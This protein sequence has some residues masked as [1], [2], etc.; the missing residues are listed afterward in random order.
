MQ[1]VSVSGGSSDTSNT[2]AASGGNGTGIIDIRS[3]TLAPGDTVTIDFEATLAA[4]IPNGTS[5][6]N[7]AQL[8]ADNLSP[9]TS[10]QTSTLRNNFV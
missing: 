1:N 7:Q 3:L 6:L 5:V 9:R 10:N 8:S 4:T 2:N